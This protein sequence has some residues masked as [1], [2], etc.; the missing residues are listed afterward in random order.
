MEM[1]HQAS[2]DPTKNIIREFASD[3]EVGE[4][5]GYNRFF[6]LDLLASEGYLNMQT[7]TLVLRWASAQTWNILTCT[8]YKKRRQW[9]MACHLFSC[10]C[11]AATRF[12][13]P[14][15]SRSAE[16]STGTSVSW[17]RPRAAT[18]S[19]STTSKR[20]SVCLCSC[21][22]ILVRIHLRC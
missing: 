8:T 5:W 18:S 16:I 4:C 10:V 1:V 2:S 7:D 20:Y 9:V 14:R 21:V 12:A 3:F 17:S 6:R 22:S 19:R 15:S 13:H 11:C